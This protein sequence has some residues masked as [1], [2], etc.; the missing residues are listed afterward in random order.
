MH[1]VILAIILF[2]FTLDPNSVLSGYFLLYTPQELA[3]IYG[4]SLFY[5]FLKESKIMNKIYSVNILQE[6]LSLLRN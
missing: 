6:F 1:F 5:L 3:D 4:I 2:L